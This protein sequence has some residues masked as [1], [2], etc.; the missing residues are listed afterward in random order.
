MYTAIPTFSALYM[1]LPIGPNKYTAM[2]SFSALIYLLYCINTPLYSF[3]LSTVYLPISPH[4]HTAILTFAVLYIYL[5]DKLYL[6]RQ[7]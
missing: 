4:K 5:I 3:L 1:Y 2:P 6:G 7:C